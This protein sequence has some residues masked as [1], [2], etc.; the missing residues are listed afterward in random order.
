M[1][2][3]CLYVLLMFINYWFLFTDIET[4]EKLGNPL[5]NLAYT[6]LPNQHRKTSAERKLRPKPVHSMKAMYCSKYYLYITIYI[7]SRI[8]FEWKAGKA[9]I[10]VI[11]YYYKVAKMYFPNCISYF[12]YSQNFQCRK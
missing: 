4:L 6:T 9:I 2:K 12:G 5:A 3:T 7:F 8:C 1:H 10:F 11:I